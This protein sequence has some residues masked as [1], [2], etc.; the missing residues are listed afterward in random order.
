MNYS[1]FETTFDQVLDKHAAVKKKYVQANDKPFMTRAL[2]KAVM[3]RS[4][5]R[6]RYHKDQTVEHSIGTNFENIDIPV[7]SYS[8]GKK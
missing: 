3:L 4:R 2:R 7:L 5:L 1:S 8:E 6:N